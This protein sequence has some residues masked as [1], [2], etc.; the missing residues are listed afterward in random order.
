MT[1]SQKQSLLKEYRSFDKRLKSAINRNFH[2][3]FGTSEKDEKWFEYLKEIL[4]I[5]AYWKAVGI[6]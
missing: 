6:S 3:K 5:E 2:R 4:R 1:S